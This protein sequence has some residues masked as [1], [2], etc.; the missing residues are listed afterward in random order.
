MSGLAAVV[1]LCVTND[2]AANL[3]RVR[4]LVGE[5]ASRGAE[6]VF[7]PEARLLSWSQLVQQLSALI[8]R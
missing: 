1:Q 4:E 3:L 2:P 6:M 8:E 7:L 5:A